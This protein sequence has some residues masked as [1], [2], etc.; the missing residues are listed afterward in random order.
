MFASHSPQGMW[1]S[2]I[3]HK[4]IVNSFIIIYAIIIVVTVALLRDC[5]IK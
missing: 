4:E 2:V 3:K 5:R 1:M